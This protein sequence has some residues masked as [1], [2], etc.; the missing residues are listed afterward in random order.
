MRCCVCWELAWRVVVVV[1][2]RRTGVGSGCMWGATNGCNAIAQ[3]PWPRTSNRR[4]RQLSAS[5]DMQAAVLC[6]QC[7]SPPW[8]PVPE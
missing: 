4:S 1:V 3:D 7:L 5:L 6:C 8:P 2:G